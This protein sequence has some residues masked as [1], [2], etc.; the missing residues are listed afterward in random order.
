MGFTKDQW[1]RPVRQLDGTVQRVKNDRWGK[2]KRWLSVWHDETGGER[3]KAFAKKELADKHWQ[4]M[5][6]DRERGEYVDPKAGREL[7]RGV[8]Q[9]WL[10]SRV[11]DPATQIRYE[12]LWRL[13]VEPAFGRRR[14]RAI[15]PSEIQAWL[16]GLGEKFDSS[17]AAGA[18]L[19]LQGCLELAVADH[20]IK[21]NPAK[22]PV[23]SKPRAGDGAR[24]QPWTDA[25]VGAVIDAH[26]DA[27]R[28]MPVLMAGCGLRVGEVTGLALE[29]IDF[30]EG[31]VHVR[32]QLKKLGTEHVFALP[33]NDRER[34]VP[35]PEWGRRPSGCMSRGIRRARARCRG[36]SSPAGRRRTAS[37]SV[38]AMAATCDTGRTASRYGSR[39][40]P[41]LGSSPSLARTSAGAGGMSRPAE[42][43]HIS[44][45]T[46]TPA[47]CWPMAC[48]SRS[49]R[50][51]SDTMIHLSRCGFTRT[52]CP[53]PTPGPAR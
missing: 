22:S 14:V 45:V 5:E 12:S 42:K 21:A 29:D 47:S 17:T 11:T 43:G 35:L 10:A 6:T 4:A 48:Q 46:T 15:R 40:P 2:G 38:G 26:P 33:K 27:L 28:L 52:C 18:Y 7:M 8:G 31:V 13:H 3:S 32:R 1:T 34:D 24:V 19:V 36:K 41:D 25:Q 39:P 50:S 23:V 9:R 37:C 51:T 49:W 53:A 20:Q 30:D 16:A 44:S